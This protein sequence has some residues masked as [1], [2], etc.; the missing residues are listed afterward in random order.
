M[1]KL[2]KI[3]SRITVIMSLISYGGV[4]AIM[5]LN[6]AD[7]L[8][9]KT[10][11][12]PITGAYEI[13]EVLLLCTVMASFAY[14]QSK[15]AHINVT[16]FIKYFPRIIKFMAYGLMGLLSTLTAVAVGYAAILQ[17]LSAISRGAQTN[18]L[19]IPLYPFYYIEALTMFVFALI[20]LYDTVLA[21]AAIGSRKCE[22]IVI[23]TWTG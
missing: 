13:T 6:V 14:A 4:L 17:A 2:G 12:R 23:S 5:V 3:I 16:L 7:V 22:E 19:M 9:L 21:F 20:L 18:V 1:F 15:K 10:L 8:L 11:S